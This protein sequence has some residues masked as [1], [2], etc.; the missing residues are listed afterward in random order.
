MTIAAAHANINS[1]DYDTVAVASIVIV[2]KFIMNFVVVELMLIMIIMMMMSM[3]MMT[4]IMM[5]MRIR[6]KQAAKL[7]FG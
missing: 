6:R 4:L 1:R 2:C 7:C 5:M 3:L